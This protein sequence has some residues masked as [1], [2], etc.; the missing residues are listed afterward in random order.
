MKT[1]FFP[2]LGAALALG[3]VGCS[4]VKVVPVTSKKTE[5]IRYS[6]P[7]P[8]LQMTR[9]ADGTVNVEFA[10]LPYSDRTYAVTASS[11]M[12]A[13][14]L[15]VTTDGGLLKKLNWTGDG[16]G[17][18]GQV[19]ESASGAIQA[20]A[21][22][23]KKKADADETA[24]TTK[25]AAA[26]KVVADAELA[27]ALAQ[28]DFRIYSEKGSAA[29]I[30]KAEVALAQANER[31]ARARAQLAD[32]TA[33]ASNAG[34]AM[35]TSVRSNKQIP[36]A[37]LYTVN[38]TDADTGPALKRQDKTVFAPVKTPTPPDLF[39]QG[40]I[41]VRPDKGGDM[42]IDFVATAAF[43]SVVPADCK[44][45]TPMGV[46]PRRTYAVPG[47]ALGS[48]LVDIRVTLPAVPPG[49]YDLTIVAR[50]GT[51]SPGTKESYTV[52]VNVL[53]AL[54]VATLSPRGMNAIRLD[55]NGDLILLLTSD[56][57]A[58]DVDVAQTELRA[59]ASSQVLPIPGITLGAGG[60][61][62]KVVLNGTPPG[63]YELKIRLLWGAT[64]HAEDS[65]VEFTILP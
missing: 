4:T 61:E 23:A 57:P 41:P 39:P 33:A 44:L 54:P 35:D 32:L 55:G 5:G 46:S 11:I 65:K 31:L 18:A 6:L 45:E 12:A 50:W 42:T 40:L 43:N 47:V 51:P 34:G 21:A 25:I 22:D 59:K 64:R 58:V 1:F 10:Y 15:G 27:V 14:N 13:H 8:V 28:S 2:L 38:E 7:K 52:P 62:V 17:L 60:T 19:V 24:R 9:A 56:V 53:P 48:K 30:L 29:E 37:V 16:S 49:I 26:E 63:T 3:G 36:G 20:H